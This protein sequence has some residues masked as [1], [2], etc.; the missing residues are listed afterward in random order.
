MADSAD[1]ARDALMA[2]FGLSEVQAIAILDM[3]LRR[4]AALERHR[5]EEEYREITEVIAYLKSLL[6]D[7][8]LILGLIK[9]DLEM[10]KDKYGDAR[11]T[12]FA[13]GS[14]GDFNIEDLIKDEA[15]FVSITARGYIKRTP[16]T[17]YR[18][19]ARG[20]KG[21]IGMS[22]RGED[23]LDHLFVA[24]SLN[25]ILSFSD[26]GKVYAVKAYDIPELDRQPRA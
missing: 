20:G 13:P 15:V 6:D 2:N 25:T 16:V 19:Q 14:D 9:D 26:L 22:T 24:G 1:D 8:K 23:E 4:L 5:I 21:L 12:Q 7:H 11:R 18:R 10:L 3:Q 17:A